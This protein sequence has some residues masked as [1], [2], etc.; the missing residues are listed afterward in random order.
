MF[1][2]LAATQRFG[3]QPNDI[4]VVLL[5]PRHR[6]RLRAPAEV[7][8]RRAKAKRARRRHRNRCLAGL[9][10]ARCRECAAEVGHDIPWG[11][12]CERHQADFDM[13]P[14]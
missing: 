5:Q 12:F 9:A 6:R 10:T 4:P 11:D 3:P 13:M 2:L 14:F 1:S 7:L 8:L